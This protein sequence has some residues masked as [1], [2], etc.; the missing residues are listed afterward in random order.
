MQ[1]IAT[2]LT[3]AW[4]EVE[5]AGLGVLHR[6]GWRARTV[7]L[8]EAAD[9]LAKA[10]PAIASTTDQC[11]FGVNSLKTCTDDCSDSSFD[12]AWAE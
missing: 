1:H 5:V 10:D 3:P 9:G 4:V 12:R 11:Q 2:L 7:R 6:Q 8:A